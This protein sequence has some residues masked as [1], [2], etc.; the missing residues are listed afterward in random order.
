MRGRLVHSA[1]PTLYDFLGVYRA[2]SWIDGPK[3]GERDFF[4]NHC[5]PPN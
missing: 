2:A 3:D 4:E 1:Q 5:E